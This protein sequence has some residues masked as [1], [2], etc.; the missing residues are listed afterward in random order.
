MN[1]KFFERFQTTTITTI[2]LLTY[3]QIS[4]NQDQ[5]ITNNSSSNL[6]AIDRSIPSE[7][8]LILF[9]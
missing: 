7:K 6:I 9:P 1:N 5:K 4:L 2:L 8:G 3:Q